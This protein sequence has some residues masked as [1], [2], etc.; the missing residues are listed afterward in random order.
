MHKLIGVISGQM[1]PFKATKFDRLQIQFFFFYW[2]T[3][4]FQQTAQI[5]SISTQKCCSWRDQKGA[6]TV[7]PEIRK[8][9]FYMTCTQSVPKY[10]SWNVDGAEDCCR[11][12]S[13]SASQGSIR[14]D[15][16]NRHRGRMI[17]TVSRHA[18]KFV[19]LHHNCLSISL[20]FSRHLAELCW[21]IFVVLS[22][23][24]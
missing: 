13:S 5:H 14:C 18:G 21:F 3:I 22:H 4:F 11:V 12:H 24:S 17:F 15:W 7:R 2:R 1:L 9:C 10:V 23:S 8:T 19:C 16:I 6:F 20:R